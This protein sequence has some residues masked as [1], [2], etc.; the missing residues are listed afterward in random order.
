MRISDSMQ[1]AFWQ[2][3]MQSS[4]Q[5]L[6]T[7]QEQI[8]TGK[9]IN[10]PSDNPSASAQIMTYNAD[11][12]SNN[13]Y[14]A[15]VQSGQSYLSSADSALSSVQNVI[16]SAVQVASEG[17]NSTTDSNTYA[18]LSQQVSS[19]VSNLV[20]VANTNSGGQ[21]IFGGTANQS[22]PYTDN[23][24]GVQPTYNGNDGQITLTT[25]PNS[26]M[27]LNTPGDQ[28]FDPIF[29]AL[30]QL[31]TDLNSAAAGTAGAQTALSND[32][33]TLQ[34][35]Q[36]TVT[37]TATV[38]GGKQDQLTTTMSNLTSAMDN[39]QQSL[40]NLQDTDL[41]TAYVQL[42]ADQNT[43]QATLESTAKAFQYSLV[44]YLQ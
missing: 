20:T 8:S 6:N 29:N 34:N 32:I 35:A 28:I 31:Q 4:L 37:Q 11:L 24:P 3:G 12:V 27:T 19:M 33:T 21:Y 7:V 22:A 2:S 43:Y 10:L 1:T 26:K 23:G 30:T 16:N 9:T 36:S 44:T 41:A 14:Q 39:F 42:E 13:Q 18:A 15:N 40:S 5:N 17:A 25:G 38:I